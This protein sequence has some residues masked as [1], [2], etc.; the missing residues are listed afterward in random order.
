M[1]V[2]EYDELFLGQVAIDDV[3]LDPKSRDDIPAVL[4]GIQ[5]IHRDADLLGKILNL[6]RS[7]LLLDSHAEGNGD[8]CGQGPGRINPN[9]GR[10]GMTLWSIL[11]LAILKQ[12]LNCDYD[13][14]HELASKHLDVRRIMGLSDVFAKPEFSYRTVLRNVALVTPE[15][16][17]AINAVVVQA[18]HELIGREAEQPLQ[19]R[20]DSFVVET[21]V[22]YPT[23]VR[24]LW[25]A[26]R[27]LLKLMGV[28]QEEYGVAGWRQYRKLLEKGRKL[29]QRVRMAKQSKR[30]PGHVK[31][32]LRFANEMRERALGSLGQLAAQGVEEEQIEQ[33]Q[34]LV[35]LAGKLEDQVERR[36]LK[37][38]VIP[39]SEKIYSI[40]VPFTRWCVK[41]KAGT[42]V[43]LGVPVC[44]VE[45]EHQ[46]VLNHRVMWSEEDVELL[47]GIIEETQERYPELEGCS[48]DKGFW[49]PQAL[50]DMETILKNAAL[51]KKGRLTKADRKRESGEAFREARRKHPGVE[52]AINNL[53]QRGL[54]RV[55]EKS[56]AGFAR[57][58]ALSI[59]AANVHRVGVI[60]RDRERERLKKRRL[61]R[62]A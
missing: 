9:V 45:D 35:E 59:L 52:S 18:G 23:D 15:L 55:R 36:I 29:F 50:A 48:F 24:L 25:D 38:E 58:V 61:K 11:V 26:L 41:G 37:G 12:A 7:H 14:L 4:Q 49:S 34:G 2:A 30:N 13:R 53:E 28:L 20:C 19:A 47:P 54:D 56:K 5:F 33:V 3:E 57:M 44:V 46:F 1:R 31:R 27:V 42:P 43:E 60:V 16:L 21:E 22:E 6:L 39:P 17:R 62:A 51:P 40:F 8:G 32:Y 10:P